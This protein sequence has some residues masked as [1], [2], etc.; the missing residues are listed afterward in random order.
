[1]NQ[2]E[3]DRLGRMVREFWLSWANS[4]VMPKAS[5][6]VPYD[7]LSEEDKEADRVIGQGMYCE[8][9]AETTGERLRHEMLKQIA[10]KLRDELH[11][12][13]ELFDEHDPSS[14]K[15]IQDFDDFI[16]QTEGV[17]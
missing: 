4:Q 17:E 14:G 13:R 16:R 15:A 12:F 9:F 1:M 8:F 7:E 10:T 5:W 11:G 2:K 6:L 3:R